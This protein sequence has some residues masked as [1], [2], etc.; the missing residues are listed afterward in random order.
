MEL[1]YAWKVFQFPQHVS[2]LYIRKQI[3]IKEPY[4]GF[5]FWPWASCW[6]PLW[7][8]LKLRFLHVQNADALHIKVYRHP[9]FWC[10]EP[11]EPQSCLFAFIV[12]LGLIVVTFGQHHMH[13]LHVCFQSLPECFNL[14]CY[15]TSRISSSVYSTEVLSFA[16]LLKESSYWVLI[17]AITAS[18]TLEFTVCL[19]SLAMNASLSP[20][21][22]KVHFFFPLEKNGMTWEAL[23]YSNFLTLKTIAEDFVH[24]FV[25]LGL[26]W[27]DEATELLTILW[28]PRV[29][30]SRALQDFLTLG[31]PYAALICLSWS[32]FLYIHLNKWGSYFFSKCDFR[33]TEIP[34]LLKR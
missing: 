27:G 31:S 2:F 7:L 23:V 26:L 3:T 9:F 34:F 19:C 13:I 30:H 11:C 25:P 14:I 12:E 33:N 29:I 18:V 15:F 22:R 20:L 5:T 10:V 17:L 16:S 1:L 28:S 32:A 8:G 21:G 6:G 24:G 4:M